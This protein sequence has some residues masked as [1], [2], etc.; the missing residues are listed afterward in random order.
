MIRTI[1]Q[2]VH[3]IRKRHIRQK[4]QQIHKIQRIHCIDK[5]KI[6]KLKNFMINKKYYK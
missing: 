1:V 5:A 2:R 3:R 4:V 6:V